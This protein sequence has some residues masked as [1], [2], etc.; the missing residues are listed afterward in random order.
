MNGKDEDKKVTEFRSRRE[1]TEDTVTIAAR[2][3]I[4]PFGAAILTMSPLFSPFQTLILSLFCLRLCH[5]Y[6]LFCPVRAFYLNS[7]YV[8]DCK[9]CTQLKMLQSLYSRFLQ[10]IVCHLNF[11]SS[12]Y[13]NI[14]ISYEYDLWLAQHGNDNGFQIGTLEAVVD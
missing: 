7:T 13:L 4:S 2:P 14:P 10:P 9:L 6:Y 3:F 8:W 5:S 12:S 11:C 1:K